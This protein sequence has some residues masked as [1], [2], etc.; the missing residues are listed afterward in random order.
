MSIPTKVF[1]YYFAIVLCRVIT[2]QRRTFRVKL[3]Y[4]IK[5]NFLGFEK[6]RFQVNGNIYFCE[7]LTNL[8]FC[9]F[10]FSY[11]FSIYVYNLIQKA[12]DYLPYKINNNFPTDH[13]A[14]LTW[15]ILTT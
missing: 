14:T 13:Q 10:L 8:L 11:N 15:K 3:N 1:S 6:V 12:Y 2:V 5:N 9:C 4:D 7:T